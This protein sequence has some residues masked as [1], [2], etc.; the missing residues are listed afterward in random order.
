M[1]PAFSGLLPFLHRH[2]LV[3]TAFGAWLALMAFDS[4]DGAAYWGDVDDV[5]RSIQ[6]QQLLEHG[7]WYDLT[8]RGIDMPGAYVSPWSRLVDL[9]YA[10]LAGL[11]KFILPLPLAMKLGFLLWPCMLGVLFCLLWLAT[12][13]RLFGPGHILRPFHVF[14]A[15]MTMPWVLWEFVPGRIDHHNVQ[16]VL[17]AAACFGLSLRTYRGGMLVGASVVCSSLVGLELLPVLALLL[18][19]LSFSWAVRLGA[20]EPAHKGI[21]AGILFSLPLSALFIAPQ[22]LLTAECDAFSAPYGLA[23]LGYA[24]VTGLAGFALKT[25]TAAV[26]LAALAGAGGLLL[27]A[28]AWFYPACLGGPYGFIDPVVKSL[29]LERVGQEQSFLSFFRDNERFKVIMLACLPVILVSA[30]PL[31]WQS[32]RKGDAAPA[33]IF[34]VAVSLTILALIQTRFVRFPA[35]VAVLFLPMVWEETHIRRGLTRRFAA[36]SAGLVAVLTLVIGLRFPPKPFQPDALNILTV[37]FCGEI[38][39]HVLQKLPPGR[40]IAPY[41]LGLDLI[42]KLPEGV[43]INAIPFHRASK[44]LRL[45]YDVLVSRDGETRRNAIDHFDYVAVC[46]LPFSPDIPGDAMFA[47]ISQGRDWP[48]LRPVIDDPASGLRVYAVDQAAFR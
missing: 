23:L 18:L 39:P 19:L 32:M 5:L 28:V 4:L 43:S 11:F 46:H 1:L 22:R 16:L 38:A 31:V 33:L 21:A 25:S 41:G 17:L 2:A 29:W 10:A 13:G 8:I 37:N 47:Q 35:G 20:V 12:A 34:L 42:G 6:I 48:G 9:P 40:V 27:A 44:G 15:F 14:V 36:V 26:R 30:L 45:M 24:C 7:R 3:L